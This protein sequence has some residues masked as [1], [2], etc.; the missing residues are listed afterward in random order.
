MARSDVKD[1]SGGRCSEHELGPVSLVTKADAA[2]E[3]M[4]TIGPDGMMP[5]VLATTTICDPIKG[6][7]F[8]LLLVV[9]Q[10]KYQLMDHDA[11]ACCETA[12]MV[13]GALDCVADLIGAPV[14]EILAA[15]SLHGQ[16]DLIES[17]MIAARILR[18]RAHDLDGPSGRVH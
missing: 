14:S 10:T 8:S 2:S 12:G 4:N 17:T 18:E 7:H 3:I 16:I 15:A 6:R 9:E 5:V 1:L 11:P 13:R